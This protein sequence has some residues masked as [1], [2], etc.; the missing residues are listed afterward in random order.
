MNKNKNNAPL[1]VLLSIKSE[2]QIE[3]DDSLIKEIYEIHFEQQ[4]EKDGNPRIA[5]M[6]SL[7]EDYLSE[8]N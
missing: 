5:K 3:V 4:Y 7:V 8:K 1:D 6:H 2:N